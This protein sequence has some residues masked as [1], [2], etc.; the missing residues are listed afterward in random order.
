M[1]RGTY[2]GDPIAELPGTFFHKLLIT[3]TVLSGSSALLQA[4]GQSLGGRSG[5]IV[6][7]LLLDA[8]LLLWKKPRLVP[9]LDM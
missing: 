6:R 1:R 4:L 9:E 3:A 8:W 5:L 2:R 7:A